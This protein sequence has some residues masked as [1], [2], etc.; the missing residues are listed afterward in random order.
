M[1]L[2]AAQ[3]DLKSSRTTLGDA[4]AHMMQNGGKTALTSNLKIACACIGVR[5][6]GPYTM[7][8][9]LVW[10]SSRQTRQTN[11]EITVLLLFALFC[12]EGDRSPKSIIRGIN[13][14]TCGSQAC[15]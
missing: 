12:L 9:L 10:Y 7:T 13:F 4:Y 6:P 15:V 14:C 2:A 8:I 5:A 11:I 3:L 1:L